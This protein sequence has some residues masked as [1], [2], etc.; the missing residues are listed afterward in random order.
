MEEDTSGMTPIPRPWTDHQLASWGIDPTNLPKLV[1]DPGLQDRFVDA[2]RRASSLM[3]ACR[4]AG[5]TYDVYRRYMDHGS[6]PGAKGPMLW[7]YNA[8]IE[9]QGQMEVAISGALMDAIEAGD[10]RAGLEV[11]SRRFPKDW[12]PTRKVEVGVDEG[13]LPDAAAV[14]GKL[15]PEIATR[16]AG[17]DLGQPDDDGTGDT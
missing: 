16:T 17:G 3:G 1:K 7:F 13:L 10:T 2:I 5:V 9:A 12:S 6:A 11:L 8:V 15:I 4:M 14:L